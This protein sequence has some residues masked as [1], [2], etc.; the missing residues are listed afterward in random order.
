MEDTITQETDGS[1][2][3]LSYFVFNTKTLLSVFVLF[4][5]FFG[6][7]AGMGVESIGNSPSPPSANVDKAT[8]IDAEK[9]IAARSIEEAELSPGG[10]TNVTI[11]IETNGTTVPAVFEKTE[12]AA[13]D[14]EVSS[15]N[16]DPF[17]EK[18]RTDELVVSW[19]E[20]TTATVVYELTVAQDAEPGKTIVLNGSVETSTD[21]I[22]I[23][24][25]NSIQI[26]RS[27]VGPITGE[28]PPEDTDDDTLYEDLDGDGG[29]TIAD[30]Q[31]FFE[32]YR[33]PIVQNS[34]DRFDFNGDGAV[35]LDDVKK[36]FLEYQDE[37]S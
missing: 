4:V 5:V 32:N 6:V 18:T 28:H 9:P 29:L 30:V 34:V 22:Q 3:R 12:P 1:E 14:I 2:G 11:S 21:R 10:S 27:S 7:S 35:S 36:L 16:P 25:T 26:V 8:P 20:T 13:G 17:V 33:K 31:I 23:S 37:Q 15:V 19:K 24:G